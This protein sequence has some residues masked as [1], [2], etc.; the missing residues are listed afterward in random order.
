MDFSKNAN[1]TKAI[2][3]NCV[4]PNNAIRKCLKTHIENNIEQLKDITITKSWEYLCQITEENPKF[5][6]ISRKIYDLW[7][8]DKCTKYMRD[9]MLDTTYNV[10]KDYDDYDRHSHEG[11]SIK[12]VDAF[13]KLHD[14]HEDFLMLVKKYNQLH[15]ESDPNSLLN[16]NYASGT[17]QVD[18]LK[19]K[20]GDYFNTMMNKQHNIHIW[21][22]NH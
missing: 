11:F 1:I 21:E 5:L 13:I 14:I 17:L 22:Y 8:T 2:V 15:H 10:D 4:N 3:I 7:G 9:L 18:M 16:Q 20:K 12:T 19:N 6:K